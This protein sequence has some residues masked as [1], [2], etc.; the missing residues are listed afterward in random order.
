MKSKAKAVLARLGLLESVRFLYSFIKGVSPSILTR[1]FRLRAGGPR[2]ALPLPPPRMMYTIISTR[3]AATFL[4]SGETIVNAME[5]ALRFTG[6]SLTDFHAILDFG[7][8][9]GRLLR[10][11]PKFTDAKL[12]GCDYN[13]ELISWSA[14]N[15]PIAKFS[16][17][18]LEPPLPYPDNSFD[19]IYARSVFT[20]LPEQAQIEWMKELHRVL[21]PG[22]A[23]YFTTHGEQFFDQLSEVEEEA[24]RRGGIVLRLGSE[25]GRNICT[26][27]ELPGYVKTHLLNGFQLLGFIPGTPQAHVRQ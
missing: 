27:F 21:A 14:K 6:K 9:C 23:L 10:H 18:S 24:V 26:S 16:V 20:H 8:G 25:A 22:G 1:E 3:W 13:S 12:F 2:E 17:N 5:E 11:L 7:C 19:F 15:L 4:D